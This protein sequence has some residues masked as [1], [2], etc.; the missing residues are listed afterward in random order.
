MSNLFRYVLDD[1][2]G[3]E[4]DKLQSEFDKNIFTSC[5]SKDLPPFQVS[6]GGYPRVNVFEKKDKF[7]MEAEVP[8]FLKE[9]LSIGLE[10]D[11]LTLEGDRGAAEN[12]SVECVLKELPKRDSFKRTFKLD[13]TKINTESIESYLDNGILTVILSKNTSEDVKESKKIKIN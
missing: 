10:G 8:G 9:K 12:D 1:F 2:F 4:L 3:E 7:V 6:L 5:K 13:L 11:L